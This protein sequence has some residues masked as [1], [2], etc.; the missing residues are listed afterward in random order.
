[1]TFDKKYVEL[2]TVYKQIVSVDAKSIETNISRYSDIVSRFRDFI[3]EYEFSA[4]ITAPGFNIFN[5][6][7]ISKDEVR[8]SAFLCELL[9]P[10]GTHGQGLLF[11]RSFIMKCIEKD[12]DSST[13]NEILTNIESGRWSVMPGIFNKIWAYGYRFD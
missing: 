10:Y 1:M 8:N 5:L 9:D 13:F 3:V 7:W 12:G 4:R 2:L 6:L 11:L